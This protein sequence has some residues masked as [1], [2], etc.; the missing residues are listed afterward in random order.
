MSPFSAVP[1]EITRH[2]AGFLDGRDRARLQAV[3][4]HMR[5]N[6]QHLEQFD[7]AI[8]RARTAAQTRAR[9]IEQLYGV[10]DYNDWRS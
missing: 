6:V 9:T 7:P 2:I 5:A 4:R 3:S 1:N 8:T 10:H